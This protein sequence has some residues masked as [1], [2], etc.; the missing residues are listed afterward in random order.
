MRMNLIEITAE[1]VKYI[2]LLEEYYTNCIDA[3]D[4]EM[5]NCENYDLYSTMYNRRR[6][7]IEELKYVKKLERDKTKIKE[8]ISRICKQIR[9]LLFIG[10]IIDFPGYSLKIAKKLR[11]GSQILKTDYKLTNELRKEGKLKDNQFA[12]YTNKYYYYLKGKFRIAQPDYY[13]ASGRGP[14]SIIAQIYN[15]EINS[16]RYEDLSKSHLNSIRRRL[17]SS[18]K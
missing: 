1:Y 13:F 10:E 6:K 16:P 11:R 15:N 3:L 7:L 18:S 14:S 8:Y 9:Q 4:E 17:Q 12:Y 5:K 2:E